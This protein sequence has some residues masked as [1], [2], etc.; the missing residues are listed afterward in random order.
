MEP[1]LEVLVGKVLEQGLMEVLEEEEL[2]AMRAHQE[3][4]EQI[5]NAELVATQ[6]MEA[7][8]RRKLEEKERRMQQERERVERERVVR[9]KVAASAFARGYLSGIVNT[10][11]DRLVNSGYI[12]DPVMREV[13]T[14]FMPWLK[15]QAVQYLSQGVVARKVV[16]KLVED[17]TAALAAQREEQA[18]AAEATASQADAWAERMAAL[19]AQLQ[20]QELEAVQQRPTFILR[21]LQPAIASPEAIELAM[22]EL[23]QQA[24]EEAVAKHEAAK[25]EVAERVR[26]EAE[27][28]AEEQRAQLEELAA[29]AAAEAEERG[30]EPPAEPPTL[31]EPLVDVEAEVAKA[32]EAVEKPPLREIADIDV[33]SYM[34]DKGTVSKDAIIQSL[35]V[36][37]LGDKAYTNHPAFAPA[38]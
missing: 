34:L 3:H 9:Q 23:Q 21:E 13:E 35:A 38:E 15:E 25:A 24:E 36:H 33:L 6:R 18:A 37:A 5:R 17:A 2:A 12:Y 30:E 31:D 4:F 20:G 26:G 14:G 28:K 10:V 19:E 7:A 8:E 27:A 11:F 32:V 16:A 1:I 29:Q 22:A